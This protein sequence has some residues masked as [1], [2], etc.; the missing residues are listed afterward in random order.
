MYPNSFQKEFVQFTMK[1]IYTIKLIK[2]VMKREN[3]NY[4]H[5]KQIQM[6]ETCNESSSKASVIFYYDFE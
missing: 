4:Q 3:K 1:N 6:L 5:E 2:L